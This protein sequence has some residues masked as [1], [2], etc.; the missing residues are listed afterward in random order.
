MGEL[1]KQVNDGKVS[2]EA[3]VAA[4]ES[5]AGVIEAEAAALKE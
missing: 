2:V 3:M 1:R 5:Q 4:L